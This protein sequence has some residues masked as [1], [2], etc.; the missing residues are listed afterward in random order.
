[1]APSPPV[2]SADRVR[3]VKALERLLKSAPAASAG[4]PPALAP[5]LVKL[6]PGVR[7]AWDAALREMQS[8]RLDARAH[9]APG[10]AAKLR[11]AAPQGSDSANSADRTNPKIMA[12]QG[13][14]WTRVPPMNPGMAAWR[15]QITA[16]MASPDGQEGIAAFV[17]K[18]APEFE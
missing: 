10:G 16:A 8:A 17:E 4:T 14:P 12:S 18:R 1:M 5:G 7:S 9:T 6:S 15:A 13:W 3:G 11:A 2:R